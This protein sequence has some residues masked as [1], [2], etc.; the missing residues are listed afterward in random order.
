MSRLGAGT[1]N[2]CSSQGD[3]AVPIPSAFKDSITAARADLK[4][5]DPENRRGDPVVGLAEKLGLLEAEFIDQLACKPNRVRCHY[6]FVKHRVLLPVRPVP[7]AAFSRTLA[8]NCVYELDNM[9]RLAR[10]GDL[11]RIVYG[12]VVRYAVEKQN[13]VEGQPEEDPYSLEQ[14]CRA[15]SC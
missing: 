7:L 8:Q 13:L 11:N 6:R 3:G 2:A 12:C 5:I 9:G 15:S 4:C 14:S 10:F 1:R